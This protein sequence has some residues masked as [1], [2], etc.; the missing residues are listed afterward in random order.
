M[1]LFG[2]LQTLNW[3]LSSMSNPCLHACAPWPS[4][5]SRDPQCWDAFVPPSCL[6]VARH[7][8]TRDSS[9][10][11]GPIFTLVHSILVLGTNVP[12]G[13]GGP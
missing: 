11:P 7:L 2:G 4:K 13:D 9:I 3:N 6:R 12:G 10:C 1:L 5:R 8:T